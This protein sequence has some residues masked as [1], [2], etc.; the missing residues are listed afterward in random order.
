MRKFLVLKGKE[1]VK[2]TPKRK[3]YEKD[4]MNT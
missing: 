1:I 3:M 4:A 2:A